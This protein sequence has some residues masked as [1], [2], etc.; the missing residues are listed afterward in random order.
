MQD[1]YLQEEGRATC[2]SKMLKTI[3]PTPPIL[4]NLGDGAIIL[5]T[6]EVQ[7]VGRVEVPKTGGSTE[8]RGQGMPPCPGWSSFSGFRLDAGKPVRTG[9]SSAEDK[10]QLSSKCPGTS[11]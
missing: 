11:L 7:V 1:F 8:P 3:D 2:S 5:G 9:Y 6:L 4:S 10:Q